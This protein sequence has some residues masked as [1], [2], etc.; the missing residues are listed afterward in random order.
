VNLNT[1]T[2]IWSSK[3]FDDALREGMKLA[4]LGDMLPTDPKDTAAEKVS[5]QVV[6]S[7]IILLITSNFHFN[8][9]FPGK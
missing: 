5:C 7:I 2:S 3:R 4:G 6:S 1:P 9:L 8:P